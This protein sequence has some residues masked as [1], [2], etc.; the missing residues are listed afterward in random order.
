MKKI[1][2]N[3][4]FFVVLQTQVGVGILSLPH[5]L[6]AA[7]KQD[8][9]ISLIVAGILIQFFIFIIW[10]LGSRFPNKTI[11]EITDLLLGKFLG[12]VISIAY[13]C[14]FLAVSSLILSLFSSLISIWILPNTP[15]WIVI[16]LMVLTGVYISLGDLRVI[17]RFFTIVSVLYIV[18]IFL[19]IATLLKGINI[20]YILPVGGAGLVPILMGSKEAFL[21]MWGFEILLVLFPYVLG[22]SR[23]IFKKMS[24]V[25]LALVLFY[26]F[27]VISCLVLFSPP[28]MKL[29][30][31]PVLYALKTLT[32][33]FISRLD[34]LFLSIWIVSVATSYMMY[35]FLASHG[36]QQLRKKKKR[37]KFVVIMGILS[38]AISVLPGENLLKI[39][40]FSTIVTQSGI[41]FAMGLPVLLLLISLILRKKEE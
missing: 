13:I 15:F 2:R 36:L 9:W 39:Q 14:Y 23:Q 7:S 24:L 20:A 22:T 16:L 8:S 30:P 26:L 11:F 27:I 25:N 33:N 32:F 21:S 34:L 17:G 37:N 10:K 31:Q 28:Q 35:L 3:Q 6:F 41:I 19:L 29:I 40:K 18:V 12:K 4:L 5:T 38:F 1:T